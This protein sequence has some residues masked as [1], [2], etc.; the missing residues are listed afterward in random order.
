MNF[1]GFSGYAQSGK[2]TIADAFVKHFNCD[3]YPTVKIPLAD[4]LKKYCERAF[5]I[6]SSGSAKKDAVRR[7]TYQF[8]GQ[9][10]RDVHPDIWIDLM[11]LSAYDYCNQEICDYRDLTV[12]VPDIRHHNELEYIWGSNRGIVF[13]VD[14]DKR[15]EKVLHDPMYQHASESFILGIRQ[16]IRKDHPEN[17]LINNTEEDLEKS[18]QRCFELF[19][20]W[21]GGTPEERKAQ[22]LAIYNSTRDFLYKAQEEDEDASDHSGV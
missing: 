22:Y 20:Q 4:K 11:R 6:Q 9:L 7:S 18:T 3:D 17:I 13:A 8:M 19:N 21:A 5:G 12:V 14:A 10:G 16:R 2:D 1:V 15:M